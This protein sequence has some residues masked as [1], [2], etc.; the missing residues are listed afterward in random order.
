VTRDEILAKVQ[1]VMMDVFDLDDLQI[2]D[3]TVA[4]DVE[5][6][7]SL[8]TLRLFAEIE[9]AFGVKFLA[10]EIV[11]LENVGAMVDAI[12]SKSPSA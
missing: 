11:A 4:D 6:W 8:S 3:K 12:A 2:N 9:G 10:R 5:G 1:D 7:D